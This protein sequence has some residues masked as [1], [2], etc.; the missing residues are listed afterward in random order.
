MLNRL[1]KRLT[2]GMARQKPAWKWFLT[3][4]PVPAVF[5][6]RDEL[7]AR[8]PALANASLPAV[9]IQESSGEPHPF[10]SAEELK[11]IATTVKAPVIDTVSR[12]E[13]VAEPAE[14]PSPKHDPAEPMTAE[15]MAA[16]Q[17][18]ALSTAPSAQQHD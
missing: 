6:H 1:R 3:S 16:D 9:F 4:L 11:Q 2:Y 14:P 10:V 18:A 12:S 15:P 5:L 7:R 8:F 13:P 17:M